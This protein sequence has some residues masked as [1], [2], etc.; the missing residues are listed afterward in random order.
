MNSSNESG[1]ESVPKIVRIHLYVNPEK[2][3][4][5][6]ASGETFLVFVLKT[7]VVAAGGTIFLRTV[8]KDAFE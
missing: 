4:D 1:I 2:D 7:A 5:T 3:L 6:F 8:L